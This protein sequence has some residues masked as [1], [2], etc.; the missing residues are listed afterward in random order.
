MHRISAVILALCSVFVFNS[1]QG[2]G[3]M[4][5]GL[6]KPTASVSG[7]SFQGFDAESITLAFDLDVTNPY[8]VPLPVAGLDWSLASAGKSFL[9]GQSAGSASIPANG[10]TTVPL[11]ARIPFQ[12]ALAV[13]S[14]IRPGNVVPYEADLGIR[15]D[16]PGLDQIRLPLKK[17]GEFP[18]PNVPKI[19]V[20]NLSWDS[21]SFTSAAA[22]VL[23]GIENT[24]D[25]PIDL[26]RLAYDLTLGGQ[27]VA[28]SAINSGTSLEQGVNKPLEIGFNLSPASLGLAAFNMLRGS[29]ANYGLSGIMDLDTPFGKLAMPYNSAGKTPLTR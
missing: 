17:T 28:R 27:Q 2:L 12:Q 29:D 21:L 19:E 24:N 14:G 8:G 13:L 9:S 3:G 22:T 20:Q 15:V 18:I 10:R 1:C 25:F 7:V 23:L 5:D 6:D 11:L 16:A 26:S 4:L